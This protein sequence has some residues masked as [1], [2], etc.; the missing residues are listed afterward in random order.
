MIPE[1]PPIF[2][3]YIDG[4]ITKRPFITKRH[5]SKEC[6]ELM[7]INVYETFGVHTS[8]GSL[9]FLNE[10]F[11]KILTSLTIK[12]SSISFPRRVIIRYLW[13]NILKR[14]SIIR[15]QIRFV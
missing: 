13:T 6:L 2:K 7:H 12:I 3:S 9:G 15:F 11:S 4:K 10:T 5:R 14:F 8:C 1:D